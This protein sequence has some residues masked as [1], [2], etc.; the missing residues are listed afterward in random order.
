MLGYLRRTLLLL[1]LCLLNLAVPLTSI[2]PPSHASSRPAS[3]RASPSVYYGVHVPGW[4]NSLRA[5]TLF[6]QDA[7]KT[8]AIVSFYQGWAVTDGTQ[9]FQTSWMNNIRAHGAIPLVTWEPWLYTAG[10]NQ[11]KYALRNIING[12]FDPY[13]RTW[14]TASKAWGHPYFLRFAEEMN[15]N[16]FPWSEQVNG[17]KPGEYVKAWRHVH[18]IFQNLGVINVS[19]VWS[20]NVEYIGGEPLSG[21]FPGGNAIDWLGMD[22]Y[23]WGTVNGHAWQTFSQ[24]FSQTYRDL[25]ELSAHPLMIAETASTEQAGK[26]ANWITDAYTTQIAAN[27]PNIKAVVWFNENIETDWRIESSSAAQTAFA[28]AIQS[29]R[30]ASNNYAA[31]N[32]SPIP[33]P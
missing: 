28:T 1:L 8:V 14:A 10:V 25:A 32:T 27:F 29:S 30:Y 5:L 13:I 26:K 2:S 19:W 33:P 31:L 7:Q 17:N 9:Y 6:E 21:L 3:L 18:T 24:V 22:G 20:P 4:L 11:P 15:G 23:N 12:N 16:W